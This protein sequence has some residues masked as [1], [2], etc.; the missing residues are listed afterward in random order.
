M[1]KVPMGVAATSTVA[2]YGGVKHTPNFSSTREELTANTH[3]K[4]DRIPHAATNPT[5]TATT[6]AMTAV[7]GPI[8]ETKAKKQTS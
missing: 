5:T 8:Y 6:A 1:Y 7:D 3:Q 2:R 4:K